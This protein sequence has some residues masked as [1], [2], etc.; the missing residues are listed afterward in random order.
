[1]FECQYGS[2]IFA[3]INFRCGCQIAAI[4]IV[5]TEQIYHICIYKQ[6]KIE[7]Q[8][9]FHYIKII[10]LFPVRWTTL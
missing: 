7:T 5:L 3:I 6:N 4:T 1:M 2:L 10:H 9:S 8:M